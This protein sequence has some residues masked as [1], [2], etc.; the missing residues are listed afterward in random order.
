MRFFANVRADLSK[1]AK[2]LYRDGFLEV[3]TRASVA[4]QIRALRQKFGLSQSE[5]AAKVGKKQSVISRLEDPE[6]S[7]ASVQSL[8][9]IAQ[10]N[11]VALLVQFVS[12]P[13]FLAGTED[14]SPEAL[15]PETIFESLEGTSLPSRT[16]GLARFIPV[17]QTESGAL[18]ATVH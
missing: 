9:E 15:Q 13:E 1:F 11:D 5:F 3:T 2:K 4:F 7:K 12:Y 16:E 10:A 8:I 6:K 14:I 17:A 18:Q